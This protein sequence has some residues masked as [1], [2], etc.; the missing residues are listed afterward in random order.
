MVFQ[1]GVDVEFLARTEGE[2]YAHLL[3][4]EPYAALTRK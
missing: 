2:D 4:G 1:D 3:M